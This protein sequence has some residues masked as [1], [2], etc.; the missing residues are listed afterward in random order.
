MSAND[1]DRLEETRQRNGARDAWACIL[2][3]LLTVS[4]GVYISLALVDQGCGYLAS[5]AYGAVAS[6]LLV[7]VVYSL[8]FAACR[9]VWR[10]TR[11]YPFAAGDMVMVTGG[12][13]AGTQGRVVGF[14]QGLIEFEVALG[15]GGK[16]V[17]LPAWRLR[18]VGS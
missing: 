12:P 13:W 9:L 7:V 8:P 14:D 16:T 4:L 2:L 5:V 18:R 3:L 6:V 15:D 10:R 1:G 11:G 17:W